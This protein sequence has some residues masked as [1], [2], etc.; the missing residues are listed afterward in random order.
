MWPSSNI[1]CSYFYLLNSSL[2]GSSH[3]ILFQLIF[4]MQLIQ[5]YSRKWMWERR[6]NLLKITL[7]VINRTKFELRTFKFQCPCSFMKLFFSGPCIVYALFYF[8]RDAI[9]KEHKKMYGLTQINLFFH[10]LETR[11]PKL[12][13]WEC[14]FL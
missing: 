1:R 13:C 2:D 9:Q 6:S 8:S 3:Y 12:R 4:T 5:Y 7:K 14:S 11:S 10:N